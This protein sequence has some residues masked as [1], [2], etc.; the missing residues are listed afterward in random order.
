ML[1][2][3]S[4]EALWMWRA[5]CVAGRV[6]RDISYTAAAA[7]AAAPHTDSLRYSSQKVRNKNKFMYCAP[8]AENTACE[9]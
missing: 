1:G 4:V 9:I 6:S 8:V 7:A 3:V 2:K 5:R